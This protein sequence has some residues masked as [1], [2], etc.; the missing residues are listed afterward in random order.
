MFSNSK[1]SKIDPRGGVSIFQISLHSKK[2][3]ISDSLFW[4]NSKIFPFFNYEISP[5][6]ESFIWYKYDY[7]ERVGIRALVMSVSVIQCVILYYKIF[8][9]C[10]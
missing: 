3:K 9:P 6:F 5:K 8:G 2:S 7:F 10:M 4:K 1:K